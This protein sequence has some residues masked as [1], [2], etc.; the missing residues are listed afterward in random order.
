MLLALVLGHRSSDLVRLLLDGRTYTTEGVVL[1]CKGLAKQTRPGNEKSLQPVVISF[2]EDTKL[3]PVVC[4]QAYERATTT[5][6]NHCKVVEDVLG[7]GRVGSRVFCSFYSVSIF[8]NS[9]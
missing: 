2:F 3:C 4:F 1:P 5:I 8:H 7:E 9:I 6:F